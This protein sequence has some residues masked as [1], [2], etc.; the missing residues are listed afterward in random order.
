MNIIA[1]VEARMNSKRFPGKMLSKI[2][3]NRQL[4]TFL[5]G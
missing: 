2:L 4:I 1:S 3:G 5:T